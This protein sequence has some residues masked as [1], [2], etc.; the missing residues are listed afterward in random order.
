[1]HPVP[2]NGYR[3]SCWRSSLVGRARLL[4]GQS[5]PL[6]VAYA[7]ACVS[8]MTS[9]SDLFK[10]GREVLKTDTFVL[11]EAKARG[12]SEGANINHLSTTSESCVRACSSCVLS[13][14]DFFFHLH[15]VLCFS[16]GA[17]P[18]RLPTSMCDRPRLGQRAFR[19]ATQ[20]PVVAVPPLASPP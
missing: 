3:V 10:L 8:V 15:F 20:R 2:A 6:H 9:F 13:L 12:Q 18:A 7:T 14:P 16:F 4:V 17:C 11:H 1:M 19:G 5:N